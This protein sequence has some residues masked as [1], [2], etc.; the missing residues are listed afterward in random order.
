VA[1]APPC[2]LATTFYSPAGGGSAAQLL[3][4]A[5]RVGA[6]ALH[7]CAGSMGPSGGDFLGE[8]LAELA[9]VGGQ[10]RRELEVL[11]VDAALGAARLGR[12]L[13]HNACA[14]SLDR[15]EAQEAVAVA[16]AAMALS[17]E[18]GARF[19]VLR[20]GP[21]AG[22]GRLWERLRPH[23]LRGALSDDE[24]PADEFMQAR[25]ALAGRHL[26]AAMRSLS[27]LLNL[28]QRLNL[29][30]LLPCP[31]R[32]LE[33]PAPAELGALRSE[34]A[35]AP[36]APLFDVPAAHL[37]S[38]MRLFPLRDSVLAFG[39]GPLANLSDSCGA[40]GGLPPG[41]GEVDLGAIV[42]ALPADIAREFAPWPGLTLPEVI[43]G[44]RG[45]AALRPGGPPTAR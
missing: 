16:T 40:V 30:V 34:F 5:Q 10:R 28:A 32:A 22:L 14:G 2:A 8:L 12:P 35:G 29:S 37:A 31:R 43:A 33:L 41:H 1:S 36:L 13:A 15:S 19:V 3:T 24:S 11:A 23:F 39:D 44:Y 25:S 9:V 38:M 21:V 27:Q 18:V 17:Q 6:T 20:P 42:R 26:D 7:L 45:V 4:T